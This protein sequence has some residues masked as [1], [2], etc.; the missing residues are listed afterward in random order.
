MMGVSGWNEL[1]DGVTI[2]GRVVSHEYNGV[3]SDWV[4]AV[5]PD[6]SSAPRL[7]NSHGQRNA[8]GLIECEI[9]VSSPYNSYVAEQTYFTSLVGTDI[10][11]TGTWSEDKSHGDKTEIHPITSIIRREMVGSFA[12]VVCWVFSDD[13][14]NFPASVPH[15]GTAHDVFYFPHLQTIPDESGRDNL[16]A[17]PSCPLFWDEP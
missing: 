11:V 9:D 6:A 12:S 7:V 10:S 16:M 4:L 5:E 15:S 3:D 1:A 17:L 2:A 13:S 14:A 8:N